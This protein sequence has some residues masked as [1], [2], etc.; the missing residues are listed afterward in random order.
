[1]SVT[2][3][4]VEI[5]ESRLAAILQYL[6]QVNA[7]PA[8]PQADKA[9]DRM[10]AKLCTKLRAG[11]DCSTWERPT[12]MLFKPNPL[13]PGLMGYYDGTDIIYIRSNLY[14]GNREEVLAHEMSHYVDQMLGLL[15]PMPVYEDDAE[16]I[17]K[18]CKS[19]AIAWAVSD[20]Y[21][22]TEI[23][24]RPSRVVGET[25]VDWYAHCTPYKDVLYPKG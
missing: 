4:A 10:W 25:W 17:I 14:S 24:G 23:W 13:R 9:A 5:D 16:G 21:N 7:K 2:T 12:V 19:E 22:T 3:S 6:L 20:A 8:T 18:L 15:P 11:I 1:M